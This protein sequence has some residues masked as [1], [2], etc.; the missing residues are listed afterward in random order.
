MPTGPQG[1]DGFPVFVFN[2]AISSTVSDF[3]IAKNSGNISP[4]PD[5]DTNY[6]AKAFIM[7]ADGSVFLVFR[8][9]NEGLHVN[10]SQR[11]LSLKGPAGDGVLIDST[12]GLVSSDAGVDS[13]LTTV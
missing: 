7:D 6:T 10:G 13:T 4:R 2:S 5:I 9:D 1:V 12:R 11:I 3:S 8:D